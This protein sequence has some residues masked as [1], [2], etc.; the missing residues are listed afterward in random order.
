MALVPEMPDPIPLEAAPARLMVALGE[1]IEGVV[2]LIVTPVELLEPDVPV[3]APLFEGGPSRMVS[4]DTPGDTDG[5]AG[6]LGLATVAAEAPLSICNLNSLGAEGSKR[7]CSTGE[8]AVVLGASDEPGAVVVL[9]DGIPLGVPVAG[10]VV[11]LGVAGVV[12]V[13]ARAGAAAAKPPNTDAIR[14]LCMPL[15]FFV[16]PWTANFCISSWFLEHGRRY[17]GHAPSHL[18]RPVGLSSSAECKWLRVKTAAWQ[19][20]NRFRRLEGI[21]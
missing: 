6:V 9:V 10:L 3:L 14:I 21:T 1:L 2:G 5:V 20:A 17:F 16:A 11:T 7:S 18:G 8:I 4:R 12:V 15:S 13:W 19:A